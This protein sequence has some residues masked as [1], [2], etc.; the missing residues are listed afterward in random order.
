MQTLHKALNIVAT[1]PAHG[2]AFNYLWVGRKSI[3]I[4]HA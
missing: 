4:K 1:S 2:F 3:Q